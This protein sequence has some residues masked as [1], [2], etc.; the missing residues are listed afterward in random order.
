MSFLV[1]ENSKY[2]PVLVACLIAFKVH[3]SRLCVQE[4]E[5]PE[6]INP[7]PLLLELHPFLFFLFRIILRIASAA[8]PAMI[9]AMMNVV[10]SFSPFIIFRQKAHC[11]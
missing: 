5:V 3:I 6:F 10:I 11:F 1:L 2:F 4:A 8:A 9:A 7:S